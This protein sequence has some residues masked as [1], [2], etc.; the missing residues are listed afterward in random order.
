MKLNLKALVAA[1]GL[2]LVAGQASAAFTLP[3]QTTDSNGSEL[4]AVVYDT[5]SKT[6]FVKDLGV[7]FQNFLPF[8]VGAALNTA[9]TAVGAGYSLSFNLTADSN[10][11]SFISQSI[12]TGSNSTLRFMVGAADTT[13]GSAAPSGSVGTGASRFMMT[14]A[15]N[16]FSGKTNSNMANFITPANTYLNAMAGLGTMSSAVDGS[17]VVLDASGAGSGNNFGKSGNMTTTWNGAAASNVTG[18]IGQ[19]LNFWYGSKSSTT[20]GAAAAFDQFDNIN[21]AATWTFSQN[22]A[23]DYNLVYAAPVPEPE[24]WGLMLVGLS[25]VGAIAR[26]RRQA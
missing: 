3:G 10:W 12:G 13:G 11:D 16:P 19:A 21:G 4:F 5:A 1:V 22:L 18:G 2:A 9:S 8:G 14:A 15:T 25:L 23:G 20:N 17:A 7:S 6:S 26:R 24:T